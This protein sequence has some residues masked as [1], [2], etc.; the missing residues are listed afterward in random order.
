MLA[1]PDVY[2]VQFPVFYGK[3][4][5]YV[6]SRV[7]LVT[8]EEWKFIKDNFTCDIEIKVKVISV[9]QKDNLSYTPGTPLVTL[10]IKTFL[11]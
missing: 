4:I 7:T 5:F 6:M 3:I 1:L 8:P 10:K 11:G 2:I 9:T